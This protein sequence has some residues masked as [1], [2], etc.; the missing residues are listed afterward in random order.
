M[1]LGIVVLGSPEVLSDHG[2][3]M[4]DDVV[5][6]ESSDESTGTMPPLPP[7]SLCKETRILRHAGLLCRKF[8]NMAMATTAE[9]SDILH[10]ADPRAQNE[11][12]TVLLLRDRI[13]FYFQAATL[14]TERL[15][16]A[17][18]KV[19]ILPSL[20]DVERTNGEVYDWQNV[21]RQKTC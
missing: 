21:H 11:P 4:E 3:T 14:H 15:Q 13:Q 8:R 19:D 7:V 20:G 16:L 2:E 18:R 12:K 10:H 17:L 6:D 9:Q 1:P 5:V